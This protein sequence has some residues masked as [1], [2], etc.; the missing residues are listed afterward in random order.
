MK[1]ILLHTYY[2][3]LLLLLLASCGNREGSTSAE[4]A[5]YI[6]E[7]PD[8]TDGAM[9]YTRTN[10]TAERP[11][12]VFYLVSTW[13]T[14]WTTDDGRTCHYADVHNATHRANMDKEISR[15]ADYMGGSRVTS[16]H[17]TTAIS[18]SK[19]GRR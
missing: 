15:I 8:Y 7:A 17:P 5:E 6:P 16:I 2:P 4:A 10:S 14:D 1:Y 11:A 18:P 13:E 9:W 3:I 19:A 12:D